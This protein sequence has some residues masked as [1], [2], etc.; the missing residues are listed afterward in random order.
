MAMLEISRG[1]GGFF[2]WCDLIGSLELV[3]QRLY[4]MKETVW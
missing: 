1:G 4:K 3:L 2:G